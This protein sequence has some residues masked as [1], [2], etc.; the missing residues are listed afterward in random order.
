MISESAQGTYVILV[1]IENFDSVTI[2]QD[3]SITLSTV[4]DD[5]TSNATQGTMFWADMYQF[6]STLSLKTSYCVLCRLGLHNW[7]SRSGYSS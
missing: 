7:F 1:T 3:V 5:A 4:V 2:P 6:Q